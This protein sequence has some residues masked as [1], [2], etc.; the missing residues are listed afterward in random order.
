MSKLGRTAGALVAE[1]K[2]ILAAD[3]STPTINKRFAAAGVPQTKE[4]HRKYRQLLFTTPDIERYIS[5]VILYD[6]TIR[7]QTDDGELFA[8]LLVGK[9]IFPG[10]KVDQGAVPSEKFPGE[11]VTQGLAGL[12]ERVAEYASMGARFAKW[13]AV[14]SIEGDHLPSSGAIEHNA[15][16]IAEYASI[17]QKGDLVPIVEPEVLM[18]GNHSLERAKHVITHVLNAVFAELQEKEVTLSELLLKTGMVLPGSSSGQQASPEEVA[19]ETI[20]VLRATVPGKVPGV[21]FLSGGQSPEQATLNLNA[22]AKEGEQPWKLTFSYSRALH[23]P[24]LAAWRG[25]DAQTARAQKL[26]L[27]RAQLNAAA[28]RGEYSPD[29]ERN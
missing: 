1:G 9:N 3:E 6:E 17:C 15:K 14:I 10:I 12:S 22:I 21:V 26:F 29:M 8:E 23:S 19:G 24:V 5:G 18:K 25:D 16:I 11:R 28:S 27:H 2:G 13:R 4:Q 20:E 7:Q